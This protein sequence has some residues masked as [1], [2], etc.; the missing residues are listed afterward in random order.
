MPGE[1][2]KF[3]PEKLDCF[4]RFWSTKVHVAVV[5]S[6]AIVEIWGM[7]RY[8]WIWPERR[9]CGE[10]FFY[11]NLFLSCDYMVF[12]GMYRTKNADPGFIIPEQEMM[13]DGEE[14]ATSASSNGS[15][16]PPCRKCGVERSH[17][18]INHCSRCDRCVEYMDHHC[19]FTDNCIGKRNYRF[20]F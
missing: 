20:F 18:R 2:S 11:L 17:D 12:S 7:A 16:I 6:V 8:F 3:N 4:Y 15:G 5:I 9:Y 10:M 13:K 19:L 14:A 1:N